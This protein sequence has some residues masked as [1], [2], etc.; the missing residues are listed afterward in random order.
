[1]NLPRLSPREQV[2]ASI[3]A[4]ALFL[5]INVAI[6][7]TGIAR[8]A[9]LRNKLRSRSSEWKTMQTLLEQR[10]LWASRDAW[11]QQNQ[12]KLENASRAGAELLDFVKKIAQE[13]GVALENPQIG[14]AEPAPHYESISVTIETKSDW[15][16]LVKFLHA[17]QQPSHFIVF[18]SAQI[19]IDPGDNTKMRA[20]L[21]IAKWYAPAG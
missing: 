5:I 9:E 18:P 19:L 13:N 16:A 8:Q 2:L 21:R 3:V 7:G 14:V 20:R 17:L 4:G 15:S 12:P 11:I 1:M 10:E 6:I